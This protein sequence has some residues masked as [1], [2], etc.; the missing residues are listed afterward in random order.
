MYD[1]KILIEQT[2]PEI[3]AA[4]QAEQGENAKAPQT[5]MPTAHP[6]LRRLGLA[7]VAGANSQA[8]GAVVSR[9]SNYEARV[10]R[11]DG[12]VLDVMLV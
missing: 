9:G 3:F 6:R 12:D 8:D 7:L 11:Y 5:E 1:R 10:A 2:D 4:I